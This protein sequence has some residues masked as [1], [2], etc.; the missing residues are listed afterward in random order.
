[1]KDSDEE[2]DGCDFFLLEFRH[3]GV[4]A[5]VLTGDSIVPPRARARSAKRACRFNR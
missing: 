1:M 2:G 4:T 5:R 3:R